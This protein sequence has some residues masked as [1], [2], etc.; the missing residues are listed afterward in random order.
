MAI[1]IDDALGK[2]ACTIFAFALFHDV[3]NIQGTIRKETRNIGELAINILCAYLIL[4][5]ES[6]YRN[7]RMNR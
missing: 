6:R 4:S 1:D 3:E 7:I 5:V 2:H